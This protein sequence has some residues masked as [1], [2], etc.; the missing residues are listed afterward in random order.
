MDIQ[1]STGALTSALAQVADVA[2]DK[3]STMPILACV[4]LTA[5][6]TPEGGRLALQAYD[7]EIGVAFSHSCEIKKPGAIALPAKTLLDVM[8]A[9]PSPVTRIK[10]GASNRVELTSGEAVFR[11]A[12]QPAS[13]FPA[14]PEVADADYL[15]TAGLSDALGKVA[16]AM[17]HDE[18]RY[19]L[20]GVL[21]DLP[22]GN[23][24]ATDGHR[25]ALAEVDPASVN[26][27][28]IVSK[29]AVA[30]L[31]K[32]LS[33]EGEGRGEFA[34]SNSSLLYRRSGLSLVARL[35]DGSFPDYRQVVPEHGGA[36]VAVERAAL[37]DALGRV[38]L[39]AQDKSS[40]VGLSF[41]DGKL[42]LTARN[43]DEGDASD[44][45]TLS[46]NGPAL[47]INVN[48]QYLMD[49]LNATGAERVEM[50][51]GD[52]TSPVLVSPAGD[53]SHT[54]VLMPMRG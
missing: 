3:K 41:E 50:H 51:L 6:N 54:Y 13:D 38:M 4:L 14:L 5:E 52:D 25:M 47:K 29:K 17:S 15:P 26:E 16:F 21:F 19:N 10:L 9:M 48:G 43:P 40:A 22:S 27:S 39:L 53:K 20:N 35:I 24:V 32:L 1:V 45:V 18:T 44:T 2:A 49:M 28:V 11:L 33:A 7:L 36:P 42:T 31:R 46:G 8:K 12:G 34:F 23:L 37:R 30:K